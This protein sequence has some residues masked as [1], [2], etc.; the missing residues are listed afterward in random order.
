M[1]T[2]SKET[3][4]IGTISVLFI[5]LMGWLIWRS[6]AISP[7]TMVSDQSLLANATS[8]MTGSADAKVTMVE[9]GD[10]QCP[11]CAQVYPQIRQL[12]D[13]YKSDPE[14]NFVFRNFPLPQHANAQASAQ[15]A[16][17]A[18]A[19]GKF[20]EMN[21]ML[22]ERQSEWDE[23]ADPTTLFVSY[24][25]TLGLD[26]ARFEAEVKAKKY[27]SVITSDLNDGNRAGVNATPTV[28]INGKKVLDYN[29]S[30]LE[31]AVK[32]ALEE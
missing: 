6:P 12:V 22:Y 19:Q 8:H 23:V 13:K 29:A 15:A 4:V 7:A 28:Y 31:A 24:A 14:F 30:A 5:G 16:E 32:K 25:K 21:H 2:I 18:G 11:A 20:W 3:I 9:F 27:A 1:R 26:T 17:A 10:Y